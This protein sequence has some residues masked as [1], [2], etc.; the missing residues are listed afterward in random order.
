[1][2]DKKDPLWLLRKTQEQV[3]SI[4]NMIRTGTKRW[5]NVQL[6]ENAWLNQPINGTTT[7]TRRMK[8]WK[9]ININTQKVGAITMKITTLMDRG[10]KTNDSEANLFS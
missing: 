7:I 2:I 9:E 10:F 3:N 5:L 8:R 1:M 6:L 4:S